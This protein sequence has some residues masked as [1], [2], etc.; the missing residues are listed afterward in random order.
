MNGLQ[1][2]FTNH[3]PQTVKRAK[4]ESWSKEI[5]ARLESGEPIQVDELAREIFETNE[6]NPFMRGR[7]QSLVSN[8]RKK[9]EKE[10][11][12]QLICDEGNYRLLDRTEGKLAVADS[13]IRTRRAIN[14][15]ESAYRAYD[16]I[17][18]YYPEQASLVKKHAMKLLRQSIAA[19]TRYRLK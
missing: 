17:L 6:V 15:T 7:A 5:A 18:K 13:E 3:F 12:R 8:L 9:I 2:M 14:S 11:N 16:T 4:G 10:S 19:E 1:S